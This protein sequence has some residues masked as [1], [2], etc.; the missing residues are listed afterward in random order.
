MASAIAFYF[1]QKVFYIK[2]LFVGGVHLD[3]S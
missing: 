3:V 2:F 1:I